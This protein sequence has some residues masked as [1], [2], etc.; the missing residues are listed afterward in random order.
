MVEL[1]EPPGGGL[2]RAFGGDTL[3]TA[4]YLAR[5]GVKAEYVTALGADPFS[6]EMIAAWQSEGIGT[7]LIPRLQGALPGLYLIRTD[8]QGERSFY[9]WRDSAPVRR[10]FSLPEIAGIEAALCE[11]GMIYFSGITLSLFDDTSR[12]RL[13][14]SLAAAR[15]RGA[16]IV[17]DT[18][19]R[20]RGWPDFEVG[21]RVY[22]R[23]F[24]ISD[25]VLVSVE[26]HGLL[27]GATEP[28]AVM[29]RLRA[30]E[31]AEIVVK[32]T[33]P[34]CH[35]LVDGVSEIVVAP[36]VSD[37]VDTTAAGDSF[38]AAYMA[39]RRAGS[40]PVA[41]ARAG[42]LLA[43]TVVRHRGAI[44]PRAAMP[45]ILLATEAP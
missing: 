22:E 36:P 1:S 38:A 14:A 41:A 27:F 32:F 17:F 34:A 29:A 18:N 13:F 28:E 23:A 33:T 40:G 39:A 26:D 16:H 43:G 45:T 3:N 2:T 8:A 9:Y 24:R 31:V 6:D 37:V 21:R 25:M 15:A 12:D 42:H 44:I 7:G 4:L 10:L 5:L 11:A 30:A 20:P 35:V 19:F